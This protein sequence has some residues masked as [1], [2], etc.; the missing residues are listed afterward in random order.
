MLVA[1]FNVV[2]VEQ[3][4]VLDS[5]NSRER[6]LSRMP[7]ATAWLATGLRA[8]LFQPS[9][10]SLMRGA[11]SGFD[12]LQFFLRFFQPLDAEHELAGLSSIELEKIQ[13]AA[14]VVYQCKVP[15]IGDII[16]SDANRPLVA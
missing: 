5:F 4:R 1:A 9:T 12:E 6:Q 2:D 8:S 7:R 14:I 15:P 16:H 10:F 11:E 13:G 3:P